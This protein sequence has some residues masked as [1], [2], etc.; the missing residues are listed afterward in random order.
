[1]WGLYSLFHCAFRAFADTFSTL[2]AERVV[3]D[4]I[5]VVVLGNSADRTQADEGA[6]MVVRAD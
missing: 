1:M 4:G 3:D 2:D 6:H 5:A